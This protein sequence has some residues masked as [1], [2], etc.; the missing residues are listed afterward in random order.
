MASGLALL[1]SGVGGASEV[2]EDNKSGLHFESGNAKSLERKI[3]RLFDEP[4]L[5]GSLQSKGLERAR[6][7]FDVQLSAQQ[8]ETLLTNINQ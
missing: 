8:I 1:S 3:K 6:N 5:L 7:Q 2:F 4:D